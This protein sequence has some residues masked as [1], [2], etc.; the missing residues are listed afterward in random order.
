MTDLMPSKKTDIE[1]SKLGVEAMIYDRVTDTAFCLNEVAA[2]VL[3]ACDGVTPKAQVIELL[4]GQE[5]SADLL[6]FTLAEL[7]GKELLTTETS[8]SYDRRAFLLQW[9][10]VAAALPIIALIQAPDATRA[11]SGGGGG[12]DNPDNSGNLGTRGSKQICGPWFPLLSPVGMKCR[13]YFR[14]LSTASQ[15]R[16]FD[17]STKSSLLT[18]L[19]ESLSRS[20]SRS[21]QSYET[22]RPWAAA[23]PVA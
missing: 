3:L 11:Q 15:R 22:K 2:Q 12:S 10:K 16:H 18:M 5:H 13:R 20:Q 4:G 8:S 23:R 21:Q 14:R 1:V 9:G 17:T 6:E 7:R 19:V